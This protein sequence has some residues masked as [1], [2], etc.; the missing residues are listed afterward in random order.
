MTNQIKLQAWADDYKH[1]QLPE[2]KKRIKLS[3]EK[4]LEYNLRNAQKH[5]GPT[6]IDINSVEEI[7]Q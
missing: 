6:A 1:S 3:E 7:I 4:A 2:S 5:L